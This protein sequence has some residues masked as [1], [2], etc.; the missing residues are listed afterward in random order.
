[1]DEWCANDDWPFRSSVTCEDRAVSCS[2]VSLYTAQFPGGRPHLG[3]RPWCA[4]RPRASRGT[5]TD[6]VAESYSQ[7]RAS[8]TIIGR[9]PYLVLGSNTCSHRG[10]STGAVVVSVVDPHGPWW[11]GSR[12]EGWV[13][14]VEVVPWVVKTPSNRNLAVAGHG[15][16][17]YGSQQC[18]LC[19]G[20]QAR[21]PTRAM[22]R[23]RSRQCRAPW[24][25][26]R[27]GAHDRFISSEPVASRSR[28]QPLVKLSC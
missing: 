28:S 22:V 7:Y 4:A 9:W 20:G 8:P 1:M 19:R 11:A 2:F 18:A 13:G 5:E 10:L 25:L 16:N 15:G 17:R 26:R 14:G 12:G 24:S 21:E 27:D 6:Y 23:A 3:G